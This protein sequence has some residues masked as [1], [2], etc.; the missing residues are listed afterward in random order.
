MAVMWIKP[1]IRSER[2]AESRAFYNEV[3]GLAGGEGLDW[4]LFF[5]T[6]KR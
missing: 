5:G 4:I 6:D 2:F 3:I 1:N